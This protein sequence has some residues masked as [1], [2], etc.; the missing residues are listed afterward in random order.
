MKSLF[1]QPVLE[2]PI[3]VNQ[4]EQSEEVD[5]QEDETILDVSINIEINNND[6]KLG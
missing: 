5:T 3:L 2:K 6:S 4:K 1:A